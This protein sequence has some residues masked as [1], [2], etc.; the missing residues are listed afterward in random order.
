L[1]NSKEIETLYEKYLKFKFNKKIL[2]SSLGS[3]GIAFSHEVWGGKDLK[4]QVQYSM[5]LKNT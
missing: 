2:T 3:L 5:L 1:K 4:N